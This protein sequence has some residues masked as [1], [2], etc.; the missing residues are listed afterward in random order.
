MGR[1]RETSTTVV[2]Q[3]Q[4]PTPTPQE[5]RL[6][7]LQAEAIE[8]TQPQLVET[9]KQALGLASQ[10]LTG[11]E[12]PGFLSELPGG[13]SPEVTEGITRE[14]LRDVGAQAQ[15]SGLLDSGVTADIAAR[16]SADIRR[17]SEEFNIG[18]LLNLLNLA[19]GGQAQIQ[20]PVL[21]QQAQFGGQLAG[22]RD[23]Q[24]SG[25]TTSTLSRPNPFLTSFAGGLGRGLGAGAAGGIFGLCWVAA[26]I[27]GGWDKLNTRLARLYVALEAPEW[28]RS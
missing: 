19:V 11:Q 21:Q 5:T 27:Y 17:A 26:E 16:T 13:I 28:F 14:A 9:Q 25:T 20:A 22:L 12:L 7:D 4:Q 8:A 3:S 2:Q 6:L 15:F 1:S 18:N 24:T 23:I 10:L